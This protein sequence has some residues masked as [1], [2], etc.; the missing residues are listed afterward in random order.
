MASRRKI[1]V[2]AVNQGVVETEGL[3]AAGIPGS[4]FQQ[5]VEAQTP[6][7]RISQPQDVA[8][9]V[10]FLASSDSAWITGENLYAAHSRCFART[11]AWHT[12]MGLGR[13][14]EVVTDMTKSRLAGFHEYQPTLGSFLDLFARLR[15]ERIIPA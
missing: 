2:H 15:R 11:R 1:R 9:A 6:L 14:I 13:E 7:G 5:Q 8:P 10:G 3:Y 12:D 4:D